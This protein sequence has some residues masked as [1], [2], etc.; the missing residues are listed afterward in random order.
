MKRIYKKLIL[1]TLMTITGQRVNSQNLVSAWYTFTSTPSTYSAITTG[2]ILGT[3]ANDND[4]FNAVNIGFTFNYLGTNYTKV[5]VCANGYLKFGT[6]LN[7][8]SSYPIGDSFGDDSLVCAF[9]SDI[10]SNATGILRNNTT[11]TAP[12]RIFTLQWGNYTSFGAT[13]NLNFQIKLYEITNKIDV[14]YGTMTPSQFVFAEVGLRGNGNLDFNNRNVSGGTNTW[15]TSTAGVNN[16]DGCNLDIGPVFKPVSGQ[17]YTWS[18]PPA[19]SGMPT[20]GTLASAGGTIACIGQLLN[21]SVTGS[22]FASG[23]TYQWQS[24]PNGTA[25]T[26]VA[27]ATSSVYNPTYSAPIYYRRIIACGTSTIATSAMSFTTIAG[28]TYATVPFLEN[29]DNTWQSRCGTRNVPVSTYWTSYPTT[30]DSSWRRQDDGASANWLSAFGTVT[31]LTGAGAADFHVYDAQSGTS[32]E[33]DLH[34]NMGTTQNYEVSFYHINP[35]GFGDS[36]QVL[37]STNGGSTFTNKGIYRSGSINPIESAWNK[38][39]ITLTGVN[40]TSCVVRFK[41]TSD[42]S[43]DIGIDSL[44]IVAI[45]FCSGTPLAGTLTSSSG[46]V[47]CIGTPL[48]LN[49]TGSSVAT[50][51]TYQWQSSP[52]GTVWTAVSTAT[53]ASYNPTYTAP[54]YYRRI[55]AC[56]TNT[57]ATNA[58]NLISTVALSYATVPFLENFDNT[59]QNR[60]DVR[61]V[62]LTSFWSSYPTA[63]DSSWRRQDDGISAIWNNNTSGIVTPLTGAGAANFHSYNAADGTS[64][65][66][67]LYVNMGTTQNYNLSFYHLNMS[68]TDSFEVFLSTNGGSTFTKKAGY[69]SGSVTTLTAWDKKTLN[70]GAVNSASCVIKFKATSDYGF[71][72]IGMDSLKIVS[73]CVTPTVTIVSTPTSVCTG[74]GALITANVATSYT[75]STGATTASISV[76]PTVTTTYTVTESNGVGCIATKTVQIMVN[77]TP[78]VTA[79]NATI[80]AGNAGSITASGATSYTWSTGATM[81]SIS[82]FPTVTT[83]YTVTGSNAGGCINTKTVQIMVNPT[84]TVTATA[85]TPTICSGSSTT[86]TASGAITYT[87]NPGNFVGAGYVVSPTASILYTLTGVNSI[88][89]TNVT[90]Q[91]VTVNQLPTTAV[92]GPSQTVCSTTATLNANNA[93][94]GTGAWTLVSGTGTIS[95]FTSPSIVLT[96]LST[97]VN[98]FKWTISNGVC[99]ASVSTVSITGNISPTVSAVSN[100]SV[101][102]I[103]SSANLTASGA[104]TYSWNTG[105]T[106]PMVVISP[107]STTTYTVNGSNGLCSSIAVI[108]Q[109]VS[110]CSGINQLS[111]E[112]NSL[113]VYP[114]PFV[115][116]LNI[117]AGEVV[118]VQ[119]FNALG[120]LV[121]TKTVHDTGNINTRNICG[122]MYYIVVKGTGWT[123]TLKMVK[124]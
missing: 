57:I 54:V 16:Y 94:T 65:E 41:A 6:L 85:S 62:P 28:F 7:N 116:E 49:V 118:N 110:L 106:T 37:L 91:A 26:S 2:T 83:T 107:T 68:G 9:G 84:P 14:I 34:I 38:K 48:T 20:A 81:A 43:D 31:P 51:L 89:C 30:S 108:T 93:T 95:S 56:G 47:N 101:I 80:C 60:C 67:R 111:G 120:E 100:A 33:L 55:V 40:S 36:L 19:C 75:W 124:Q 42:Y 73:V 46:T 105:A 29:F 104:T 77:P 87:W 117:M 53:S 98:V 96:N 3:N 12:N 82:V 74:G 92:A 10:Q 50:G 78:T 18:P 64:G 52:N 17:K 66:M 88:G 99:P 61:N 63:S 69:Q 71:S 5:S 79:G 123:K 121:M 35:Y 45:P 109:S 72:D 90:T 122:G 97:G 25:W 103:G 13:D 102:C 32:G 27:S 76:S 22:T 86:L 24:S 119:L 113:M 115:E 112:H 1:L 21:L 4:I 44:K 70:L 58:L 23:L 8:Y 11:G 39:S 15:A 59:W 114:N